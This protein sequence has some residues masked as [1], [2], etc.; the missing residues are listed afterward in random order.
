M[1]RQEFRTGSTRLYD[2]TA[3][4]ALNNI[5]SSMATKSIITDELW[6]VEAGKGMKEAIILSSDDG[7]CQ[8][9]I[10]TDEWN[11]RCDIELNCRGTRYGCSRMIQYAFTYRLGNF[12][13][14]LRDDEFEEIQKKVAKGLGFGYTEDDVEAVVESA[15]HIVPVND[16]RLELATTKAQ[17]EVYKKLY[18]DL[19]QL[20]LKGAV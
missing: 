15:E 10:L 3:Y 5:E 2:D 16:N 4:K 17:L 12:I 13:R 7:F 8:I 14:T 18:T 19:L 1:K 9:I 11:D 6:E 20:N